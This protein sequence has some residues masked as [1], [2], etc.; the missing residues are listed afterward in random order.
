MEEEGRLMEAIPHQ[1]VKKGEK[2]A[3]KKRRHVSGENNL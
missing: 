2:A 3:A 1:Q